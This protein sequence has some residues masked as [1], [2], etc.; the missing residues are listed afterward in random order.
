MYRLAFATFLLVVS[1]CSKPGY[2]IGILAGTLIDGSGSTP[3]TNKLILI[4]DGKIAAIKDGNE[5]DNY[6][7]TSFID[8]HDQFIIP[9]LY[10]MHGHITMSQR[11]YKIENGTFQ[12]TVAYDQGDAEWSMKSLLYYGITSV[13]ET[14]DFLEEGLALQKA[15]AS[16]SLPGPN[17]FTCGPLIEC[18]PAEFAT[19]STVVNSPEEAR[20]EVR[21]QVNAGV[22]FIKIYSTVPT[23]I[24]KA[25]IE[26]AHLLHK[27]VI[28][29]LGASTWRQAVDADIDDLVH[30]GPFC[31]T[32]LANLNA[33]STKAML[34]LMAKKQIANDPTLIV[35]KACYNVPYGDSLVK[36]YP[37]T[38]PSGVLKSW[39]EE[40]DFL[41]AYLGHEYD[42]R[43]D[44]TSYLNFTKVAYTMGVKLLVG[45][46]FNNENV[47]PGYSLHQELQL[48]SQA[49]IPNDVLI[50]MATHD[51]AQ[52]LGV[53]GE[54]GTIEEGKRADLI[55]LHKN[56]LED[57]SNTMQIDQVFFKGVLLDRNSLVARK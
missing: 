40:N 57:I 14:A 51:A 3:Q 11:T 35:M 25:V 49:G 9:G 31:D 10:D 39:D 55:I 53:L 54:S 30:P 23:P 56:P 22:D 13:R 24:M 47:I 41:W 7:M 50:R 18:S 1:A 48:M 20:A 29:H 21:R 28:G 32:S 5:K 16:G 8:A 2:D 12:A 33:D 4:K 38:I 36:T 43:S 15:T 37:F 45:S 34:A 46:D 27:K 42:Y 52:W 26:E 19:M 6:K 17:I 44:F